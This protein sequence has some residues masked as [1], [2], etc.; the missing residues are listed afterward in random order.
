MILLNGSIL[1]Q[2]YF[3]NRNKDAFS[4]GGNYSYSSDLHNFGLNFTYSYRAFVDINMQYSGDV[5]N[6]KDVKG[7]Y[8]MP[9]IKYYPLRQVDKI[10]VFLAILG[11]Y[12]FENYTFADDTGKKINVRSDGLILGGGLYRSFSFAQPI[13]L[14][15]L[16]EYLHPNIT[17][18]Q[19]NNHNSI[20]YDRY[21]GD[22]F[23]FGV[24]VGFPY[25]NRRL[26]TSSINITQFND[27]TFFSI[28]FGLLFGSFL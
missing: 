22:M 18:K 17:A 6:A 14:V 25:R 20:D 2:S 9:G 5:P 15:L 13:R 7:N 4:F 26:I 1:A 12:L 27:V 24:E 8:L 11:S 23:R 16:F 28:K 3:L 21:H 10:P 19:N